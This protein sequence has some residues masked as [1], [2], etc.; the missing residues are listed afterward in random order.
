MGATAAAL[1]PNYATVVAMEP[2]LA[3]VQFMRRRFSQDRVDNVRIVRAS[4]PTVPFPPQSF[5]LVVFNGVIE[6]LPSGHPSENPAAVQLA[7][8]RK[9]FELLRRGGHVYIGIENRW[10]YEYFLGAR[11]P[12][13]NVRW[14]TI[15]P[16]R[17]ANWLMRRAKADR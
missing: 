6:W 12:H 16:R 10:C 7:G 5:D 3:R 1:S 4:F 11:D 15:V 9:A 2:V 13:A 8:L 14:V 17:V